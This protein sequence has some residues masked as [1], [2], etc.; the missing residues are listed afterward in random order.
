MD[1]NNQIDAEQIDDVKQEEV[2]DYKA[3][4]EKLKSDFDIILAKKEQLQKETRAA[5]AD[6]EN[7]KKEAER[8]KEEKALKDGEF[9]NLWKTEK[10]QREDLAKQ[11]QD[12]RNSNLRE[13]LNLQAIKIAKNLTDDS[14]SADILAE[15]IGKNLDKVA[16]DQGL[17]GDDVIKGIEK[18]Y[19]NNPKFKKLLNGSKARGGA[20]Q[21]NTSTKAEQGV[22]QITMADYN[23]LDP[24]KRLEIS[25]LVQAKKAEIID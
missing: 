22:K 16:D 6:R 9:E 1:T 5:K 4:Y 15:F 19:E 11:L 17:V 25:R 21:G 20:A 7:A 18:D 12:V 8:I 24:M 13:K 23:K 10:Q 14:D 3:E 2:K